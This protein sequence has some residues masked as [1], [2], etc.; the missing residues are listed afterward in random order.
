MGT[1][2]QNSQVVET[3]FEYDGMIYKSLPVVARLI[4][5]SVCWR[6]MD[7]SKYKDEDGT[8]KP[9]PE[10]FTLVGI[11]VTRNMWPLS[12]GSRVHRR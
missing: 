11:G 7:S 6:A 9:A 4:T 2:N 1:E 8:Q 5:G 10:T 12:S 3:G